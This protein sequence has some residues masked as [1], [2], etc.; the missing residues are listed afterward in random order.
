MRSSRSA[1]ASPTN[2]STTA[3]RMPSASGRTSTGIAGQNCA[4]SAVSRI[5]SAFIDREHALVRAV[6]E[7]SIGE[8]QCSVPAAE[9]VTACKNTPTISA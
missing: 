9:A 7:L 8:G 4:G 5:K 2:F 6:V 1:T 3:S